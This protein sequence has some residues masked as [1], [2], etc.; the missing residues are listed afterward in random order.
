MPRWFRLRC[1]HMWRI[2]SAPRFADSVLLVSVRGD[3]STIATAPPFM[4]GPDGED[5]SESAYFMSAN[6]NKRSVEVDLT[7][8]TGQALVVVET[9]IEVLDVLQERGDAHVRLQRARKR[10]DQVALGVGQLVIGQI[11]R[12]KPGRAEVGGC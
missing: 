2:A 10:P 7:S 6:R 3:V 12:F 1:G 9:E 8:E 11:N 4:A 5:T